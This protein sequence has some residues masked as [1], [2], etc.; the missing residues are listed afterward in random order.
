MMDFSKRTGAAFYLNAIIDKGKHAGVSV[1]DVLNAVEADRV[2]DFLE[3]RF[4]KSLFLNLDQND[5]RELSEEWR[6][7]AGVDSS[8][9]FDVG[10]NGICL[11]LAFVLDGIQQQLSTE[12]ARS[13]HH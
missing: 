10:N 2:F 8:R 11:L 13:T 4:G 6:G 7:L 1:D 9:K 5:R 3:Q 12:Q